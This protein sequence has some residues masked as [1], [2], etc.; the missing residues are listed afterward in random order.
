M[1]SMTACGGGD[2]KDN[3]D[4]LKKDSEMKAHMRDSLRDDS[5]KKHREDSIN[6]ANEHAQHIKDSL[7][8][9]SMDK[10]SKKPSGGSK[11]KTDAEKK[12]KEAKKATG[13]R[14]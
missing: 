10:A 11:P 2:K 12:E 8:K 4:S 5:I 6:K 9:D 1:V 7:M 13:G 3:A 14:G